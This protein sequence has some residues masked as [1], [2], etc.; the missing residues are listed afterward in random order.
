MVAHLLLELLVDPL[1]AQ[2]AEQSAHP[3]PQRQA[4]ERDEEQQS[5]QQPPKAAPRGAAPAEAPP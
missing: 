5:E 1:L 3:G 4:G 2:V